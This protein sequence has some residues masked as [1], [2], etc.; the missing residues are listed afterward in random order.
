MTAAE[1][2]AM[3]DTLRGLRPDLIFVGLGCPKQERWMAEHSKRVPGVMLGVG[4]AF[5]FHAG[6]VRQAPPVLQKAGMEWAFRLAVEPRRLWKRYVTTN[7]VYIAIAACQLIVQL[8][9]RRRYLLTNHE[10]KL[11]RSV[12]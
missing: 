9:L 4:A 7:P 8:L 1:D 12:L 5:D 11:E 3:V 2:D 6:A 10:A